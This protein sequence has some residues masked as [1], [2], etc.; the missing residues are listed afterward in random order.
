MYKC[1]RLKKLTTTYIYHLTM[2]CWL[3]DRDH[4]RNAWGGNMD[5]F[6]LMRYLFVDN[7]LLVLWAFHTMYFKHIIPSPV[8]PRSNPPFLPT[9]LWVF[10]FFFR[11]HQVQ[12][13]L[14]WECGHPLE[15][16]WPT[17]G[18]TL[19]EN[20][21]SFSQQLSIEKR[22]MMEGGALK[23]KSKWDVC[24]DMCPTKTYF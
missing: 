9:Q 11:T 19:E 13:V 22:T 14:P 16:G 20:W 8:P 12:F 5:S 3:S 1:K 4:S 2:T 18:H 17:R 24:S 23:S 6:I 21:L 10:C 7:I 15:L